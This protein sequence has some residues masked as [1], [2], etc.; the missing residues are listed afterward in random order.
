MKALLIFLAALLLTG[1]S[2][3][4]TSVTT[5]PSTQET[6]VEMQIPETTEES[7]VFSY[8][9]LQFCPFTF[10]SGA[11]AWQTLLQV[12]P[13]GSFRGEYLDSE[14]GD[15]GEDYPK[16]TCYI[17][18]FSGQFGAA[19]WVDDTTWRLPI[20]KLNRETPEGSYIEEGIRYV[21]A[22]PFGIHGATELL[23]YCPEAVTAD[24]PEGYL[25][26]AGDLGQFASE[27]VLL[28]S[29]G[30]Y[31]PVLET[32]FTSVDLA[33]AAWDMA[34][35]AEEKEGAINKTLYEDGTADQA[36]LNQLAAS[37]YE[38]WD[39][40]LN[41]LWWIL[42]TCL[43]EKTME[44]LTAEELAWIAQKE[45][46]AAQAGKNVEGGT[47]YPL[48][49]AEKATQLTKERIYDLLTWFPEG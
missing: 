10:A 44:N 26:W 39:G 49:T 5:I 48:V 4:V 19:Q 11:G 25:Q 21:P 36:T 42:K 28:G 34:D 40:V 38:L 32:G 12:Y 46:A 14:M 43:D 17:A 16:G 29:Y 47:L 8:A 27:T 15:A 33:Q 13:D 22:D 41:D 7:R 20:V 37:Q 35:M 2:R 1:C 9:E 30:L 31:S 45:E 6:V 3:E 18:S 23:L 24:L